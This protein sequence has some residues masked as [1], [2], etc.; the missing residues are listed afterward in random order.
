MVPSLPLRLRLEPVSNRSPSARPI[1]A[2]KGYGGGREW[3][4]I[5]GH[6]GPF[7]A[8]E[9]GIPAFVLAKAPED[10]D[11]STGARKPKLRRTAW[12]RTQSEGKGLSLSAT[13]L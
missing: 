1:P 11:N 10:K 8:A 2:G 3:A 6:D 7:H 5:F 13:L 4:G 12:S 9:T